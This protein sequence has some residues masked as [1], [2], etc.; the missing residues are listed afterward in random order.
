MVAAKCRK[1]ALAAAVAASN[2]TSVTTVVA[3]AKLRKSQGLK[4]LATRGVRNV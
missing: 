3:L 4:P 2:M 1:N